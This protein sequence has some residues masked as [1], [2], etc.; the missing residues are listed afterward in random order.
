MMV[1]LTGRTALVTGAGRGIGRAIALTVAQQGADVAVS[2]INKDSSAQVAKEVD[3]LGRKAMAL[4]MDVTSK[5]SVEEAFSHVL[6]EWG[7]L[8]ILVNNAGIY[9]APGYGDSPEDREEDWDLAFDVNVKGIVF[10]CKAVMPHMKERGY[11]K[12]IN[13]ASIGGR[14]SNPWHLHYCA[15]KAAVINYTQGLARH[16]APHSVNVNAINPGILWTEIWA[17][18]ARRYKKQDP[19]LSEVEIREIADRTISQRIPMGR[20]QTPEDIGKT[21]AFLA[22]EDAR[23]ITGQAIHVDGG[24][25]ML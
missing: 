10:C 2:D 20:E 4:E 25:V 11:G 8:D 24:L 5:P 1:D 14:W 17:T 6:S 7:H 19:S 23:N 13:I 16:L 3:A 22:S 21:A 9:A 12:I 15:S 18:I